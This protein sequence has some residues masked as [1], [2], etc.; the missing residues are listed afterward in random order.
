[1]PK[2]NY[3]F[4]KYGGWKFGQ[5]NASVHTLNP[6]LIHISS[7]KKKTLL[8]MWDHAYGKKKKKKKKLSLLHER[9]FIAS[10]DG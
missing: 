4:P 6:P 10:T 8:H 2:S 7:P 3:Y 1:M 5:G 9:S